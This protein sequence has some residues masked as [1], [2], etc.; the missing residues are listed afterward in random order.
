MRRRKKVMTEYGKRPSTTYQ[1]HEYIV[2]NSGRKTVT[3][4]S[5][6]GRDIHLASAGA[7]IYD[8]NLAL[9]IKDKYRMDPNVYVIEKPWE[10][11]RER[12]GDRKTHWSVPELPWRC[13]EAEGQE[14]DPGGHGMSARVERPAGDPAGPLPVDGER[15][16]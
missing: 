16:S 12:Q 5:V 1:S 10:R 8:K 6:G 14:A 4:V 15:G 13:K 3:D 2:V 7:T 9:E 11:Y